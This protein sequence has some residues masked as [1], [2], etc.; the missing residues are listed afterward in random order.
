MKYSDL[1]SCKL[2]S[3][4]QRHNLN[5]RIEE[6]QAKAKQNDLYSGTPKA[7]SVKGNFLQPKVLNLHTDGWLKP[8]VAAFRIK[9]ITNG[10]SQPNLDAPSR[11]SLNGLRISGDMV[12]NADKKVT[13]IQ[14]YIRILQRMRRQASLKRY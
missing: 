8:E 4:T 10:G 3:E 7:S 1:S 12:D 11:Q 14:E 13:G 9:T 6:S 2:T 5:N